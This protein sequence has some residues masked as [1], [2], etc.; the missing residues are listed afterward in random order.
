[1]NSDALCTLFLQHRMVRY[2]NVSLFWTLPSQVLGDLKPIEAMQFVWTDL[3]T[4][5]RAFCVHNNA[6]MPRVAT[7]LTIKRCDTHTID[8]I[9]NEIKYAQ[10][11]AHSGELYLHVPDIVCQTASAFLIV[12]VLFVYL[13]H[14]SG[15][16]PDGVPFPIF[17]LDPLG[18]TIVECAFL[19]L[20]VTNPGIGTVG[21]E[22]LSAVF[23]FHAKQKTN[24][25]QELPPIYKPQHDIRLH[26]GDDIETQPPICVHLG[27]D[28]ETPVPVQIQPIDEMETPAPVHM[29]IGDDS[30]TPSHVHVIPDDDIEKPSPIH[31]Q[32]IDDIETPVPVLMQPVD[33]IVTPV[34]VPMHIGDDSDTPSHVD[35]IPDDDIE[36]PSPIHMQ[37]IDDIE[38]SV[39]VLVQPIDEIETPVPIL[40]QPI[41][42]IETPVPI[43]VH[44][45]DDSDTPSPVHV[46]HDDDIE[47]QTPIYR[48]PGGDTQ[49]P[50]YRSKN[51]PNTI[52]ELFQKTIGDED[53]YLYMTFA[54]WY[55]IHSEL[56]MISM[57]PSILDNADCSVMCVQCIQ[58]S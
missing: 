41:A 16:E 35:V 47:T 51:P 48:Q 14:C 18:F 4:I 3:G 2:Q 17:T 42:G 12:A 7:T 15:M 30:D 39:P 25:H 20:D 26:L 21:V 43:L 32:P 50:I 56:N 28:I 40:M 57:D 34:P 54:D 24:T 49:A 37:P 53:Y 5:Q 22:R 46:L 27:D 55:K 29:H 23:S 13:D 58:H 52:L 33:E 38:T 9:Y 36:K 10:R 19:P 1:M 44:I 31:M 45:G 11:L 8:S 6:T